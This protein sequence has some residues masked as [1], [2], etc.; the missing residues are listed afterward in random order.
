M[1]IAQVA[2]L[3]IP[4]PPY[5]YGGTEL[6][7]SWLTEELVKRG[8]EVTLFATGD[9]KTSARLVPVWPRSLWRARLAAPHA[10][11]SLMYEKLLRMQNE[12]DII[13]DHCEFYTT[14]LSP[15]LKA[16]VISTIH[17]PMYEE[18]VVLFKKF[19]KINYVTI[20]KNQKKS[21]PG[22]NSVKTIY[23]GLPISKYLFNSKPKDYI[24]WLS[25]IIPK[26]GLADAV[27][28]AKKA[29][30]K[31]IISGVIPKDCQDYFEYRIA[32]LID[33]KQIQFV[34]AA[35][36]DKKV[37][38]FR[39]AK[40]FLFPV[41]RPE[42]FG[43]VVVESMATGT[44][45]IT[46]REGSMSEIIKDNKTGF[47][48]NSREEMVKALKKINQIDRLACRRYV[49][50]KFSLKKMVNKYEALYHTILKN[51]KKKKNH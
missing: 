19:P 5:T 26:K 24:L 34:G 6:L 27:E 35:D 41:R 25:K 21:A 28:V 51:E 29:G 8:H 33:G 47:L 3:W 36:F 50:R 48:V 18:M 10:V 23:H 39:N 49:S 46:Y 42:P 38:L 40:A 2:P 12:F 4:I 32:P 30:E 14:P 13:H 43:L 15:F 11:F 7:V 44:P 20:S 31:L 16:P 37:E 1:R 45:V 9:S 17:H 22:I